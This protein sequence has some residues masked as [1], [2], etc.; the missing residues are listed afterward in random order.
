MVRRSTWPGS[1]NFRSAIARSDSRAAGVRYKL[2]GEEDENAGAG[3]ESPP[4]PVM[5]CEMVNVL[6]ACADIDQAARRSPS[7][8]ATARR[9]T[10]HVHGNLQNS[11]GRSTK[12]RRHGPE[13]GCRQ[14]RSVLPPLT[15]LPPEKPSPE[16]FAERTS[17]A[18]AADADGCWW[19]IGR[20]C[21]RWF[22]CCRRRRRT[23]GSTHEKQHA[24]RR[25]SGAAGVADGLLR[26]PGGG[27]GPD[28]AA[29]IDKRRRGTAAHED[30]RTEG[31]PAAAGPFISFAVPPPKPPKAAEERP[32][33][34]N[35]LGEPPAPP[36]AAAEAAIAADP[37]A[38]I[39]VA[40]PPRTPP[41]PETAVPQSPALFK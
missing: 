18:A 16:L 3:L 9:I 32:Q 6:A 11:A 4:P 15:L 40:S 1:P 41:A 14:R 23:C 31:G 17:F 26:P 29:G 24:P 12:L 39:D 36:A 34:G 10:V 22:G 19:W 25:R 13:A 35:I 7:E 20:C 2:L 38:A 5:A 8:M 27:R 37:A 30:G 33:L 28:G 21:R